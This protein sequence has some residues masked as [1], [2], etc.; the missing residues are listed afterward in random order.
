MR[1]ESAIHAGFL[2]RMGPKANNEGLGRICVGCCPLVGWQKIPRRFP[3]NLPS[4]QPGP[5]SGRRADGK[6]G[7]PPTTQVIGPSQQIPTP[8]TAVCAAGAGTIRPSSD[9]GKAETQC[10]VGL[11]WEY[12]F[13]PLPIYTAVWDAVPTTGISP[14]R[15]RA[16]VIRATGTIRKKHQGVPEHSSV[17]SGQQL[18]SRWHCTDGL[19]LPTDQPD[20]PSPLW[21][22]HT[23]MLRH[24]S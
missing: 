10:P 2:L 16:F 11:P 18:F 17:R 14:T 23:G 22:P 15:S 7:A 4:A 5:S 6:P 8:Q 3:P 12:E 13:H 21:P 19:L 1:A 24:T 9:S 20:F